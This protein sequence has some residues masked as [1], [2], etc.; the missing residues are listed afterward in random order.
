MSAINWV[1]AQ[2]VLAVWNPDLVSY[3][4][5]KSGT[6]R[7]RLYYKTMGIVCH[8]RVLNDKNVDWH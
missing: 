8:D 6:R 2:W 7:M 1:M 5:T 3:M 4:R